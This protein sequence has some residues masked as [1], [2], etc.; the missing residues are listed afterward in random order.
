MIEVKDNIGSLPDGYTA[1]KQPLSMQLIQTLV[2]QLN[3]SYNYLTDDHGTLFTVVFDKEHIK[4][5]GNAR[6]S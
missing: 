1:T 3:G 2:R 5:T 4:G 6:L